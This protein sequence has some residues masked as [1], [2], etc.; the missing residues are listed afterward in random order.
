M[1]TPTTRS[2]RLTE[3][4][5]GPVSVAVTTAGGRRP[6][7]VL[8]GPLPDIPGMR[9]RLARAGLA[10]VSFEPSPDGLEVVLDGI[11][12]GVLGVESDSYALV[13]PGPAGSLQVARGAGAVRVAAV[14]VPG[15][16]GLVQW[17]AA[18]HV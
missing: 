4:A 5:A 11:G 13:E 6:V 15:V 14:T 18:H 16:D 2:F 12:R 7:V 3:A 8:S 17:L 9:D 10:V 1:A